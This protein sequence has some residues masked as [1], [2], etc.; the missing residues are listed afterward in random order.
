MSERP[1][2]ITSCEYG[3]QL[4]PSIFH[5]GSWA[6]SS[7]AV[8]LPRSAF[9]PLPS[10]PFIRPCKMIS[11]AAILSSASSAR[12][13]AAAVS[14]SAVSR[15]PRSCS[16]RSDLLAFARR[17]SLFSCATS[18]RATFLSSFLAFAVLARANFLRCSSFFS[19][20][21]ACFREADIFLVVSSCFRL[22]D[23]T[24]RLRRPSAVAFCSALIKSFPLREKRGSLGSPPAKR[25]S[26]SA[27][28]PATSASAFFRCLSALA[29]TFS[30]ARDEFC[31]LFTARV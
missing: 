27:D 4:L 1:S 22:S 11:M 20:S 6:L 5:R 25:A 16:G 12:S 10:L 9:V 29:D 19:P 7:S 2:S 3:S 13:S 24:W 8:T 23:A 21:T 15:R 28:I 18:C 17:A 31:A 30:A 14:A 26:L